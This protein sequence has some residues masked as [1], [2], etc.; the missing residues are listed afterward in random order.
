MQLIFI[1]HGEPNYEKD[2][3]TTKGWHEAELLAER[4]AKLD[5]TNFY[6]SPLGRAQATASVTL[7]KMNRTAET[8]DW[9]REFDGQIMRPDSVE[10]GIVWDWYPTEW[11][12][13][14]RFF[15]SDHWY[16]EPEMQEGHVKERYQW[17]MDNF[18]AFLAQHGYKRHGKYYDVTNSNHDRIVLFCHAGITSAFISRLLSISPMPLWH[19]L[20]LAPT[21]VTVVNSEERVEGTACFRISEIGDISHLYAGNEEP[22]FMT[23]FCECY[24]DDTRH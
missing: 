18:D 7:K 9:L 20:A 16:D 4:I 11:M 24:E 19:G 2:T 12:A 5:V 10:P 14:D 17:V 15:D 8:L 6:V 22:S 3:L 1:R 23:R 21:S 13:R